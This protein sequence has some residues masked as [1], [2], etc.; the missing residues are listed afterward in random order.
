MG[1]YDRFMA[2]LERRVLDGLRREL[3]GMAAGDVL[4]LGAKTGANFPYYPLDRI[5]LLV[6]SDLTLEPPIYRNAPKM[7]VFQ[8]CSALSLPFADES[9]DTVVETLVFCSVGDLQ[10]AV[11]EVWRVLRPGGRLLHLDHILPS[12]PAMAML[13]RLLNLFWPRLTGGCNLTRDPGQQIMARG[14]LPELTLQD[15]SGIFFGGVARKPNAV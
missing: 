15:S 4:E 5:G 2:P 8:A 6:V 11:H 1:L 10:L 7:A 9:F 14:F 13:F 3:I 12:K